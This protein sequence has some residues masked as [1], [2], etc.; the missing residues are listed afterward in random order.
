LCELFGRSRQAYYQRS[1][2][3]YKQEVKREILSQLVEKQRHVMPRIGGRKLLKLIGPSL[4]EELK[5]GRDSFFEFLRENG[6]LVRKRKNRVRTTYSNHWLHK[7]P[8]LEKEFTP[9]RPHQLLVGD[10]TYIITM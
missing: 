1:K 5:I 9:V 10:I 7:Y 3:S 6:L 4:P 8:N 2:Y